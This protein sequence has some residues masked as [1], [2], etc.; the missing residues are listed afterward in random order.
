LLALWT[1][2][3]CGDALRAQWKVSAIK[4]S[5]FKLQG[6]SMLAKYRQALRPPY[7]GMIATIAGVRVRCRMR[8]QTRKAKKDIA[9]CLNF[10]L[11][12]GACR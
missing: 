4:Q 6:D 8:K 12:M 7:K 2:L 10:V 1:V 9:E 11:E 5:G 3:S